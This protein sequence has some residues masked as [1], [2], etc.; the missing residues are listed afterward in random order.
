[1]KQKITK[2]FRALVLLFKHPW[3]LNNIINDREL[4]KKKV[5][6]TYQLDRGLPLL[7]LSTLFQDFKEEVMPFAFLDGGSLPIDIAL[8]K[9]LAI[10]F[11]VKDYF[12]IGTWRGE[13]AANVASVVDRCVTMYLP[14][15][16]MKN[17]SQ[18]QNYIRSH[19]LFSKKIDNITHIQGDSQ[20]F[21]FGPYYHKCDMV[22]VDG[23]HHYESVKKD[24][25]TA[26]RLIKG[27][28][29]V[30]V[31]HDYAVSPETIRWDVLM[32][33][34][35][36]CPPSK[37]NNLYHIGNTLCAAYIDGPFVKNYLEPCALNIKPFSV[38][39]ELQK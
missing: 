32:G 5:V 18:T 19:G 7:N 26:F 34:L 20:F 21:D 31:W 37:R 30:I 1:M 16:T 17:M 13:S 3:L 14:D 12:E 2:L 27:D 36:G 11:N 4:Y 33:I 10:K 6:K 8:L 24:T 9:A 25:A 39:I 28:S 29:S 23:D 15:E 38:T 22:F 35:D